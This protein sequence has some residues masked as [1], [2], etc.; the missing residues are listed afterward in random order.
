VSDAKVQVSKKPAP[1]KSTEPSIKQVSATSFSDG[2]IR[3]RAYEIYE[4]RG[5]ADNHDVADWTQAETEL[6]ELLNGKQADKSV[7]SRN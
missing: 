2:E 5:R 4:S 7:R 3:T 6:T 1:T